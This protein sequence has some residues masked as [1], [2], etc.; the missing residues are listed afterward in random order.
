MTTVIGIRCSDGIVIGTDSQATAR[1]GRTK[2][3]RAEKILD[4]NKFSALAGSGDSNH[5]KKLEYSLKQR[6]GRKSFNDEELVDVLESVLNNLYKKY[7]IQKSKEM[8][9]RDTKEIFHPNSIFGTRLKNRRFG[10]YVLRDDTWVESVPNYIALGS[11]SDLARLVLDMNSRVVASQNMVL[12]DLPVQWNA[13]IACVT[14]NEVKNFDSQ[15]GGGTRIATITKNGLTKLPNEVIAQSYE[16]Y[17]DQISTSLSDAFR[18]DRVGN[19]INS[20]YPR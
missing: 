16:W 7:C 9:F 18:D 6:I 20:F 2:D 13:F 14:I 11:G 4:I 1:T 10:L 17:I 5:V 12:A 19:M 3:L 15:S 8:G